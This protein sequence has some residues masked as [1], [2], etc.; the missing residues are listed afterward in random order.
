M[1]HSI[2]T[3]NLNSTNDDTRKYSIETRYN[4][5][6]ATYT[7]AV[8]SP[9]P[10]PNVLLGIG[11][12]I[13][14]STFE[15]GGEV[16]EYSPIQ[17]ASL[18]W[19]FDNSDVSKFSLTGDLVDSQTDSGSNGY[20]RSA[21][22][23]ERPTLSGEEIIF[24][25]AQ[26]FDLNQLGTMLSFDKGEFFFV[27]KYNNALVTSVYLA[28]SSDVDGA[29]LEDFLGLFTAEGLPLLNN[30]IAL[31]LAESSIGNRL[32]GDDSLEN[33]TSYHILNWRS[34]G[35]NYGMSI[36]GVEQSI[37]GDTD[38]GRWFGDNNL[39]DNF[40]FGAIKSSSNFYY[41]I[42]DKE[43]MYFNEQ[44]SISNRQAIRAFK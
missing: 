17:I 1:F 35:S 7:E 29:L 24:E 9:V 11:F 15:V 25:G 28:S 13:V 2:R 8:I 31:D 5:L 26:L 19:W 6:L 20:I 34:N 33:D 41:E 14:G 21:T 38:N 32:Y 37:N 36:D 39:L 27:A 40:V 16:T 23:T 3:Y 42:T 18:E 22:G 12:M 4:S 30:S 10:P 44:L 43:S